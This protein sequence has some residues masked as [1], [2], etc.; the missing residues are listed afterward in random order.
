MIDIPKV[1]ILFPVYKTAAYLKEAIDSMLA[2][3]FEDFELIVLNDCSPDNAEEVMDSYSDPRIIRYRGEH[4]QGLANVLN[5]GMGMAR[6]K[7]IARM[8]SDDISLPDRL[9]IQVD[10]LDSHPEVGLCSSGMQLFGTRND[11]WVRDADMESIKFRALFHS[12]IL[13]AS[14]MWRKS[15]FGGLRFNQDYVPAE[16]YELWTRALV[17]GCKMVNLPQV[18]YLYRTFPEQA[19][20]N[21]KSTEAKSAEVRRQYVKAI[22]P[23]A[24]GKQVERLSSLSDMAANDLSGLRE[25]LDELV[26]LNGPVR[27]FDDSIAGRCKRYYQSALYTEM[28][29]HGIKWGM[30]FDLRAKQ[31][32]KLIFK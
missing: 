2:Q 18:L 31:I 8:D 1:S 10:Y 26:S 25:A 32:G 22:F 7:Y 23:Q 21:V 29:Q 9:K 14:S 17:A 4:N 15:S 3:T 20:S 13:H 11:V 6:G 30:L 24:S 5:V 19:T 28:R 16:D 12:P 27:Y